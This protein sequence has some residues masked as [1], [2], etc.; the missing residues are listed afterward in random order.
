MTRGNRRNAKLGAGL[1]IQLVV[2]LQVVVALQLGVGIAAAEDGEK[3]PPGF[4]ATALGGGS[5]ATG[6]VGGTSAGALPIGG[7]GH[8]ESGFGGGAVGTILDLGLLDLRLELEATGGRSFRFATPS[9]GGVYQT[10]ADI[11]T[12]Q[13]NFWLVYSFDRWFPDMWGVRDLSAFGGGGVGISQISLATSDGLESGR[14]DRTKFAWQ[15]GVGLSYRVAPWLSLETRYQ[16]IDMGGS[17]VPLNGTG[18]MEIDL[19]AHEVVGGVHFRF[20]EL[21]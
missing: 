18:K 12:F 8:D 11:W 1:G 6:D 17:S 10:D 14:S 19:G 5:W 7:T 3:H 2:A 4:Y 9:P 13:G 16:Y 21:W 15:G 20:S